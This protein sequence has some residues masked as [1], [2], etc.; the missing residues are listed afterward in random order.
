MLNPNEMGDR[1]FVYGECVCPPIDLSDHVRV[2]NKV[3][4]TLTEDAIKLYNS[5]GWK[6][7]RKGIWSTKSDILRVYNSLGFVDVYP[8]VSIDAVSGK[9]TV[10]EFAAH[11]LHFVYTCRERYEIVRDIDDIRNDFRWKYASDGILKGDGKLD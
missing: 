11:K 2:G 6:D 4:L 9:Q 1:W 5:S 8:D 3:K 10:N 7:T